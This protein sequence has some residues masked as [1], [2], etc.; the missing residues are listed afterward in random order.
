MGGWAQLAAGYWPLGQVSTLFTLTKME[1]WKNRLCKKA[2]G[3]LS[4]K[5][6]H[7]S[8]SATTEPLVLQGTDKTSHSGND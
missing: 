7:L 8:V 2:T 3:S 6:A 4:L 5:W 1:L